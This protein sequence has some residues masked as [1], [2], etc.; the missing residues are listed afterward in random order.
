M[1][2]ISL[3]KPRNGGYVGHVTDRQAGGRTDRHAEANSRV[4]QFCKLS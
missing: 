2:T 3:M 4:S 1:K